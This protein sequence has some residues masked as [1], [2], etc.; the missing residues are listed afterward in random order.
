MCDPVTMA[1]VTFAVGAGQAV[2]SHVGQNQAYAANKTAANLNY[3]QDRQA[4]GAQAVE[5]DQERS[6]KAL[7]TAVSTVKAQGEVSAS[8]ADMGLS[9]GSLIHA[10]NADMF[11]IGRQEM[12]DLTNDQNS[13]LQLSRQLEGASITRQTTINSMRKSSGLDLILGVAKAGVSA[14]GAYNSAGGGKG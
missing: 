9:S 7:D 11:G 10:I 14:A 1:A 4:V 13:R 8:A 5:L 6:E 3:A 2:M 12:S